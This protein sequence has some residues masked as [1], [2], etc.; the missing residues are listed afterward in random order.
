MR[1]VTKVRSTTLRL[2]P[3]TDLNSLVMVALVVNGKKCDVI[4][5]SQ[6]AEDAA[7]LAFSALDI[8]NH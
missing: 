7:V 8:L 4:R 2:G 3:N 1:S 5:R 6:P